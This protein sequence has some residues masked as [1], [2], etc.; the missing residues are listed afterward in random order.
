MML[1]SKEFTQMPM[2]WQIVALLRLW[3]GSDTEDELDN[4]L[5]A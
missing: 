5:G 2:Y 4:S 1:S 3:S